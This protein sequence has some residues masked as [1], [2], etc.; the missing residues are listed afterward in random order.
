MKYFLSLA[1]LLL[2]SFVW[3]E[4]PPAASPATL[5]P[6]MVHPGYEEKPAW[7]KESFLDIR[8]DIKEAT[9]ADK[10]VILY[11]YQ[12]GCPYCAKLIR[13]N[14][15]NQ[16]IV[17]K[18]KSNFDVIAINMWGD[19]NVTDFDGKDATEKTFSADLKVQYTPTMLF[20]DEMGKV[21]LR[22]NGY[23]APA[24]FEL[25]LDYAA[26]KHDKEGSF[27]D[28]FAKLQTDKGEKA[29]A[30]KRTIADSLPSPLKLKD[31][32]QDSGRP[33]LVIFEQSDCDACDELHNDV[34]KRETVGYALS[35]MDVAVADVNSEENLQTLDGKDMKTS[36]WAKQLEI[37]YT[38]SLVFFDTD[39]KEVFRTEA[40]LKTYHL[41]GAMDYVISG[42]YRWQPEFQRFL[43][44]RTDTLRARGFEVN[45]MD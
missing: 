18:T 9:D 40:Y 20:L 5:A 19:R 14:F 6:G 15:G 36:D 45:L 26:G 33:L 32:R 42:A 39:G 10:R 24:K 34:L 31:D 27:R 12:D 22:V 43:Q 23:Y 1:L 8:E 35:N 17:D 16:E 30:A 38:P 11:F 7:F 25:A 41:H 29:E 21:I 4:E 37:K 3:A 13:E 44:H 28:Y 2:S